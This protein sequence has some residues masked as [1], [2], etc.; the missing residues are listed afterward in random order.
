MPNRYKNTPS[1]VSKPCAVCGKPIYR[2]MS[3]GPAYFASRKVCSAA[4]YGALKADRA[5]PLY[6]SLARRTRAWRGGPSGTC[7][8]CRVFDGA[9]S[10]RTIDGKRQTWCRQCV[11]QFP[12]RIR[13]IIQP[14][15]VR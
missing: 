3:R 15:P 7:P 12:A 9:V 8:H 4:C 10:V 11:R 2:D 6:D 1:A 13:E 5:R 14:E